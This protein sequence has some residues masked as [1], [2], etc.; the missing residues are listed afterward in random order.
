LIAPNSRLSNLS[1]SS[2]GSPYSIDVTV[3]YGDDDLL[4]NPHSTSP[5]C[6]GVTGDQFCAVAGLNTIAVE[7]IISPN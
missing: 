6:K 7:R 1:V 3:T 4:N 2:T 5:T